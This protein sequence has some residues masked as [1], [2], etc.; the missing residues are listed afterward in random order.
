MINV[1]TPRVFAK[2]KYV[3]V[4]CVDVPFHFPVLRAF[5]GGTSRSASA[6]NVA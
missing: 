1:I 5:S 3:Y 4:V 6:R 2:G